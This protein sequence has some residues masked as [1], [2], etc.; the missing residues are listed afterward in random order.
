MSETRFWHPKIRVHDKPS[1]ASLEIHPPYPDT[2][3]PDFFTSYASNRF[4]YYPRIF[5]TILTAFQKPL[6]WKFDSKDGLVID[7]PE[8]LQDE[9][10]RP[11]KQAYTFKMQGSLRE[12]EK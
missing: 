5:E 3:Y 2:L 7:I 6:K 4:L 8:K 11:C 10:N 9:K 12:T 1:F